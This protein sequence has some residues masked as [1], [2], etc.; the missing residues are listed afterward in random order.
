MRGT[1][2]CIGDELISGRVAERNCRFA[3]SRLNPLG[4]AIKTRCSGWANDMEAIAGAL[5][6]ALAL[7]DFVLVSGGRGATEDGQSPPR[8]RPATS[9][10]PWPR[11]RRMIQNLRECFEAVGRQVPPGVAR[12]AQ[13]PQGAEVLDKNCAGFL[14]HPPAGASRSTSCL[15]CRRRTTASWSVRCCP[16]SCGA[17][18]RSRWW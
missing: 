12:M 3:L 18:P 8:P 10:W 14:L 17:S 5:D 16:T 9:A 2:I 7:A 4:F 11:A 13:L 6:Q 15:G 1:L